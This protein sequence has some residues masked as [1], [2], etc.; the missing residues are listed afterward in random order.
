MVGTVM[1]SFETMFDIGGA[2]G[3]DCFHFSNVGF[4]VDLSNDVEIKLMV[5]VN[6]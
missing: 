2:G 4:V 3:G 5:D 1:G 6:C